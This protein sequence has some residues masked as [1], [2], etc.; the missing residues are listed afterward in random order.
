MNLADWLFSFAISLLLAH[1]LD[2]VKHREW[3]LLFVLRKM[4]EPN[5]I[6]WF[7]YLHLPLFLTLFWSLKSESGAAEICQILFAAFC[8]VHSLLHLRLRKIGKCP[9]TSLSSRLLIDGAS[10]FAIVFLACEFVAK[11]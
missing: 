3:R 11:K 1:E 7:I 4:E 8:V 9:F 6:S 2:A 10:L 5:A